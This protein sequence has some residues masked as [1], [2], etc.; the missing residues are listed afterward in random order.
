MHTTQFRFILFHF[1][2]ICAFFAG[3]VGYDFYNA[4]NPTGA[5]DVGFVIFAGAALFLGFQLLKSYT[6][7]D[8]LPA[9]YPFFSFPSPKLDA[10][11]ERKARRGLTRING[12]I[13]MVTMIGFTA[14]FIGPRLD[15]SPE[16]MILPLSLGVLAIF[17]TLSLLQM[18]A[19]FLGFLKPRKSSNS[20][21]K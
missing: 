14:F 10:E 21:D 6:D 9:W 12:F 7:L 18:F 2:S 19:A 8:P 1:F 4:N 13:Y 20:V 15:Y 17:V 3:I 11:Q 16:R 5:Q